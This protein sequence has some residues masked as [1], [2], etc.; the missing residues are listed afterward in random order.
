MTIFEAVIFDVG[1]VLTTSP[2]PV[3]AEAAIKAGIGLRAF[4]GLALGPLDTDTDH[5][6]HRAERGEISFAE[7]TSQISALATAAGFESMPAPPSGAQII[8]SM[9][10]VEKMVQFARE[11][12]ERG[13]RVGIIT[14]N[15]AEWGTWRDVVHAHELA[16]VVIDSCEVGLRKPDPQIYR[17]ALERLAVEDSTRAVFLDDFAW[18]VQGAA[19]V[20]MATVHVGDHAAAIEETKRLLGW[21]G[22]AQATADLL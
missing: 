1:G 12:R 10:P 15:I 16:D 20:G 18:N 17:L 4:V 21:C 6:W 5:P 14:N 7:M 19:A 22:G 9:Q 3:M 2:A 11:V 8:A 13:L